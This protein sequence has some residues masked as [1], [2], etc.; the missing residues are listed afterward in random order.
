MESLHRNQPHI[1]ETGEITGIPIFGA[2]EKQ[3]ILF[4]VFD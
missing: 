2:I 1:D 4:P 3:P